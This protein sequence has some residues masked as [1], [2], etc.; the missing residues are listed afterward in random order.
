[1][2]DIVLEEDNFYFSWKFYTFAR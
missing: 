1:M 2:I